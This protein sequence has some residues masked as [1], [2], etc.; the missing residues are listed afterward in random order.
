MR[1]IEKSGRTVEEAVESALSDLG[2]S[3]DDAI[4]EVIEEP[5]RGF[6]GILGGRDARV[7]VTAKKERAEIACE[8]IEGL[9]AAMG[10][11]GKVEVRNQG[12]MWAI[13]VTGTDLGLLIGRH[14]ETLRHLEFLA[15]VVSSKGTGLARRITVDV[16]GY[17][18]RREKDLE[19]MARNMA[20]R[21]ERTGRSAFLRPMDARDRR[22]VHMTL[23]KNGRVV[24][25]S[26]GDEP[27]RRVVV[28]PRKGAGQDTKRNPV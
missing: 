18:K 1:S 14:G 28:S 2:V 26:E 3:E 6:L 13:D 4:V 7:R 5:T 23:Q 17:R 20:R 15:N 16:G 21:V 12:D 11:A 24:T 27:F 22:I 10:I 8:F 9:L 25:H 19:E